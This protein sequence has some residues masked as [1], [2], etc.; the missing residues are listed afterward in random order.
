MI[1]CL[2]IVT[3]FIVLAIFSFFSVKIKLQTLNFIGGG[4]G[5]GKSY[6]I[7]DIALKLRRKSI[8]KYYLAKLLPF[9]KLKTRFKIRTI[10]S[11]YPIKI[12]KNLWSTP[13]TRDHLLGVTKLEE[14]AIVVLDEASSLFP[15]QSRK[16]DDNLI[17]N[18]RFFRH[19]TN[20]T[21]IM[22]DQSIGDIDI[23][24]RRRINQVYRLSNFTSYLR[25]FYKV[26]V[27]HVEYSEDL[28]IINTNDLT[29]FKN[30]YLFGLFGS[31]HYDSRYMSLFYQPKN[32]DNSIYNNYKIIPEVSNE[33]ENS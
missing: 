8:L 4:L 17:Y 1:L 24:I 5:S 25:L 32:I 26:D 22:A 20:G 14:G 6:L 15:N 9:K 31:K 2:I 30:R 3:V 29:N 7:T 13:L 28:N 11:N 33:T 27:Q 12:N 19:F 21:L 23:A 10:Y 16:S 18:I